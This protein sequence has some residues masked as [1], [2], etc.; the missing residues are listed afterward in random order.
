MTDSPCDSGLL[1]DRR[2]SSLPPPYQDLAN[3]CESL[4]K[5]L[6]QLTSSP[7]CDAKD[8]VFSPPTTWR[9][10]VAIVTPVHRLPLSPHEQAS[11]TQARHHL[12]CFDRIVISPASLDTSS[13]GLP[14]YSF[15]DHWFKSVESYSKL[16]LTERFY[17]TFDNYEFIL[18]YQLDALVFSSN[19]H[20]W[21]DKNFDYVGAPWFHNYSEGPTGG[22]WAT[23]NGGLSLRRVG[24]FLE[25]LQTPHIAAA[26][27]AT[28]AP[29]DVFWSLEA[30]KLSNKFRVAT[31]K[32]SVRFA[33]ESSP[34]YCFSVNN[35]TLPFG[36]HYWNRIDPEFW[37]SFLVTEARACLPSKENSWIDSG[38]QTQQWMK[39]LSAGIIA[40]V[41]DQNDT[42]SIARLLT[43]DIN[44]ELMDGPPTTEGII[45]LF[46]RLL[47]REPG[48][49]WFDFW[50]DKPDAKLSQVRRDLALG[51]E[52][53]KRCE[54]L[55]QASLSAA[56]N[57]QRFTCQPTTSAYFTNPTDA[58]MRIPPAS[59]PA[60][61]PR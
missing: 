50:I 16:L 33:V 36:C 35:N 9:K 44:E 14:T 26:A 11:L 8:H 58:A 39:R 53:R 55:K 48:S 41:T 3:S 54:Q 37:E 46:D 34:R 51:P 24:K 31:P 57:N 61:Q 1:Q 45:M 25:L 18:I 27:A 23:G 32:E 12:L 2:I 17:R 40:R 4:Y 19:L 20:D 47:N 60:E 42:E 6:Q 10:R 29:E 52:F 21:C 7:Q 5:D 43:S 28:S 56:N 13:I 49:D 22:L 38:A 15:E 30:S 59:D